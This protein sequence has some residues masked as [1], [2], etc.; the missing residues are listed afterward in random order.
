MAIGEVMEISP[1]LTRKWWCDNFCTVK[2]NV[3]MEV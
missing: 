3:K 1:D 2:K